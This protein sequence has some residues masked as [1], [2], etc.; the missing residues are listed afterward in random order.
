MYI[1]S[2][3]GCMYVS[4]IF[5]TVANTVFIVVDTEWY[6]AKATTWLLKKEGRHSRN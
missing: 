5:V 6:T 2:N 4:V 1:C 3:E